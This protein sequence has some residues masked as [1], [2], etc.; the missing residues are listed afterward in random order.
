[1]RLSRGSS[2]EMFFRLWTLAPWTAM[3]VRAP[4]F[5]SVGMEEGQLLYLDVALRRQAGLRGNL[6]DQPL[7]RQVFTGRGRALDA[8]VPREV[9]LDLAARS[10]LADFAQVIENRLEQDRR[11][12]GEVVIHG[13]ERRLHVVPR[14]PRIEQVGV[15]RLEQRWIEGQCLRE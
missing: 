15:D 4:A 14:L 10:R 2:S 1:M 8:E 6:A 13:L 5:L 12:L 11:P 9:I 3:V 7:V